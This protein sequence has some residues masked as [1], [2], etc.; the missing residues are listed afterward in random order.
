MVI[1][2]FILCIFLGALA[3]FLAGLL[4]IGGGLVIVPALIF[5]LPLFG[6]S[7]ELVMPVAIATSLASIVFTT[8]SSSFAHQKNRNIDWSIT[9]PIMLT[10]GIGAML[11]AYVA[12]TLSNEL[13]TYIFS[14]AVLLLA[15]YMLLSIRVKNAK[16]M[17]EIW[18]MKVIGLSTGTISSIMGIGGGAILV[19][20][21]SFFSLP[22]RQ[23]IGTA[24]V[25]GVVVAV[26]GA[27]GFILTGLDQP[28]MPQWSLG[29]IYLPA[30][31][32]IILTS[33]LCAP[34]GV[35]WA[36]K[37]PVDTLKRIFA[38]FLIIVAIK[39]IWS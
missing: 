28:S 3:G 2:I 8:S 16:P 20:T 15:S 11:G 9:R 4:G 22:I 18:V 34:L 31:L 6:F 17:P 32:G 23:A 36:A 19:P 37:L 26:F 7:A 10:V 1:S 13:L 35:K 33:S 27:L 14:I 25:C 39:M 29:Y 12:D 38:G 30:L 21:L 24:S 5:F